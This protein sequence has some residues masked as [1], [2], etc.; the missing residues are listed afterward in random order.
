MLFTHGSLILG[1]NCITSR[2][3]LGSGRNGAGSDPGASISLFSSVWMLE[4]AISAMK[5]SERRIASSLL[6]DPMSLD[7]T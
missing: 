3:L 5:T 7:A 2:M 1:G 6:V 4:S